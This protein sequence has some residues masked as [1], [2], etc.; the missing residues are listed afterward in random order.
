MKYSKIAKIA[1][2][3]SLSTMVVGC[4]ESSD[5][6][7]SS[8]NSSGFS[9]SHVQGTWTISNVNS[10]SSATVQFNSDKSITESR[11]SITGIS[12]NETWSIDNGKLVTTFSMF[13][14]DIS[15]QIYTI[16]GSDSNCYIVDGRQTNSKWHVTYEMC[17][18]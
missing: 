13:G 1:I 8:S 4:G 16:V 10:S 17:K 3:L 18:S 7:T 15:S 2:A 14:Q 9:T 11:G 6:Q 12:D 5:T